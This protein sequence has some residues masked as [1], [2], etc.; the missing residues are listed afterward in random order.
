MPYWL[1]AISSLEIPADLLLIAL[2]G[3]YMSFLPLY[4]FQC[5]SVKYCENGKIIH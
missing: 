4:K 2:D 5:N 3:I 1:Q